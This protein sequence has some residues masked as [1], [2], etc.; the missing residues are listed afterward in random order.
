MNPWMLLS[1]ISFAVG[2]A[3]GLGLGI[4]GHALA[5]EHDK[6]AMLR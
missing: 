2:L 6:R 1:I 5:I 3:M 4:L